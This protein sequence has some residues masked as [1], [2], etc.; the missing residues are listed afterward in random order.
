MSARSDRSTR[1]LLTPLSV[2][3]GRVI[4]YL[5][6]GDVWFIDR[7]H[8][9]RANWARQDW[10]ASLDDIAREAEMFHHAIPF[11]GDTRAFIERAHRSKGKKALARLGG[12]NR[13]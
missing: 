10:R 7:E 8:T 11:S 6:P 3:A 13:G 5:S 12:G 9:R 2:L 4:R 1:K